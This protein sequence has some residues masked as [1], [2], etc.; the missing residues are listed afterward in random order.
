MSF[1]NLSRATGL[2]ASTLAQRYGSVE[3]LMAA[4]ARAGWDVLN[5][6][7]EA[8]RVTAADK[9]PQGFLK[10]LEHHAGE[11]P[12]L[13]SLSRHDLQARR[14]AKAWRLA[15]ETALAARLG[16]GEKARTAA[17][18]LFMT[19]QG[20]IAWN[21]AGALPEGSEIRIKDLARQLG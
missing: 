8:A 10:A 3:G 2:A 11:M 21:A 14:A 9:G 12:A 16:T 13:L 15:V 19:W 17:R 20:Q 1:G 18:A 4:A 6:A 5:A 7:L